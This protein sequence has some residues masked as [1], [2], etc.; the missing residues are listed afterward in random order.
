MNSDVDISIIIPTHNRQDLLRSTLESALAQDAG[1]IKYEIIVVDN[2]CRD[3]S[4]QVIENFAS[5][6]NGRVRY[7]FEANEGVSYARN[8]G[9]REARGPIL[10]FCDDDVCLDPNWLSQIKKAFDTHPNIQF[11]GGKVLPIWSNSPPEWLTRDHWM[12]LAILDYGEHE[13]FLTPETSKGLVAANFAVRSPVFDRI[14]VFSETLQLK[15]GGIGSVEDHELIRR[16]WHAGEIGLY[17]PQAIVTTV[18]PMERMTKAY[19]RRWHRGHGHFFSL[20]REEEM[21][22]ATA[23]L[24]GVPSHLY[25]QVITD[26]FGWLRYA[27]YGSAARSFF[28][29]TGLQFCFGFFKQRVGEHR[30]T[31]NHGVFREFF[32]FIL[33]LI[34]R[35][36][37]KPHQS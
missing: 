4:R 28:H 35:T 22:R 37:P 17:L 23:Y 36:N 19:H 3:H 12:P 18:V 33:K 14:G 29:E 26:S 20:L 7:V 10:G 2:N 34:F 30:A 24:F 9:I 13:I 15:G 32:K 6:S 25:R 1:D 16:I 8:T 11:V 5:K 21:E 31:S 27:L